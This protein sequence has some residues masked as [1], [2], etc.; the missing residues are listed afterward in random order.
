MKKKLT[1]SKFVKDLRKELFEKG[2]YTIKMN[3]RFSSGFPDLIC[4]KK[5]RVIFMEVKVEGN[6]VTPLQQFNLETLALNGVEALVVRSLKGEK[7]IT[8]FHPDGLTTAC[9]YSEYGF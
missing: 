4:I 9:Y 2:Y 1:E 6:K 3:E 7:Y 5:G 8:K